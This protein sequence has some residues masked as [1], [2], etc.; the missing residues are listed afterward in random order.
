MTPRGGVGLRPRPITLS[1]DIGW[2]YA[3]QM[4]AAIYRRIP[5]ATIVDLAHDLPPHGVTEAAFVVRAMAARF[6]AGTVHVVVV[7]PG[8]GGRRAP[9][10]VACADG[11]F[12][13]GPDNGV[14]VPLAEALGRPVAVRLDPDRVAF[15]PRVGSTFDGRDL[16]A[17]AAARLAA[18]EPL[19]GLGSPHRLRPGP[20][21]TPRRA[22]SGA[23]GTVVHVD[24]FGNLVTDLPGAWVPAELPAISLRFGRR[25]P[26]TVPWG[27]SYERIGRGR[28]G[29]LVSS[30]G[31]VEIAIAEGNAAGRLHLAAGTAVRLTWTTAAAAHATET[32]NRPRSVRGARR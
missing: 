16:F 26:R 32:V 15:G 14:L 21:P 7:D 23:A 2:A 31:T 6:P 28:L 19:A 29:A 12:V 4:K 22:P 11:S 10:A 25:A 8:V 27:T 24:R 17:P 3:A 30:F 18:G 1:S 5:R 13:V 9:V 20:L